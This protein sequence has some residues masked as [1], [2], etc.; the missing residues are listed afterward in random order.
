MSLENYENNTQSSPRGAKAAGTAVWVPLLFIMMAMVVSML[1]FAFSRSSA[2]KPGL[3]ERDLGQEARLDLA[4]RDFRPL[5]G[6]LDALFADPKFQPVP[7]QLHPLIGQAAPDFTLTETNGKPWRFSE[8]VKKTP[9]VLV[10]YYGYFCSHCVSQLFGIQADIAKFEDL[11]ATVVAISPDLPEQTRAR[12][13]KFGAF[14][15]PVLSDPENNVARKY[16]AYTPGPTPGEE[17]NLLHGTFV[18]DREGKVRWSY[19]GDSPFIDNRTLLHEI[20]KADGRLPAR[21][22][23]A[24]PVPQR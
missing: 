10:F 6:T 4:R 8:Q 13:K 24:L 22:H 7:S 14:G 21:P 18:I 23:A 9:V 20:A 12:F 1:T 11:G 19:R 3:E 2:S 15:F 16:G 17:G 5:S